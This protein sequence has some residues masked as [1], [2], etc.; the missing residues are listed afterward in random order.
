MIDSF[1]LSIVCLV[2]IGS[3]LNDMA[4]Y[5]QLTCPTF[6]EDLDKASVIIGYSGRLVL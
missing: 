6:S 2:R 1:D 5:E 3:L 4:G